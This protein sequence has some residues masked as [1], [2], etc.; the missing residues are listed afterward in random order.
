[1]VRGSADQPVHSGLAS[2]QDLSCVSH[3]GPGPST[4]SPLRTLACSLARPSL[5]SCHIQACLFP[6]L[7]MLCHLANSLLAFRS[8]GAPE[9]APPASA[10][11]P[12]DTVP[13]F[14]GGMSEPLHG[15]HPSE[16]VFLPP[17]HLSLTLAHRYLQMIEKLCCK[18][19]GL[20]H[21][22]KLCRWWH[23]RTLYKY[24]ILTVAGSTVLWVTGLKEDRTWIQD[25]LGLP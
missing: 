10:Q 20:F 18:A 2:M 22:W 13:Q 19:S 12:S 17:P 5:G 3:H 1:M 16:L 9:L 21:S 15:P 7:I 23:S 14:L 8:L 11:D 4:Q 24:Q 25:N 6:L